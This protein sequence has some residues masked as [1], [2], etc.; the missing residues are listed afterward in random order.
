[1]HDRLQ[2]R[3]RFR[4]LNVILAGASVF[5]VVRVRRVDRERT[6]RKVCFVVRRHISYY[7]HRTQRGRM[8]LPSAVVFR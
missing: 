2:D 8:N 5:Y 6:A 1:M 4:I 3:R 7:A